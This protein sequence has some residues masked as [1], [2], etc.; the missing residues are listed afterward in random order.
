[1]G[2]KELSRPFTFLVNKSIS[3]QCFPS[4]LKKAEVSPLYKAKDALQRGNYRP[5]SIL[6]CISKLVERVYFDDLYAFFN[7]IFSV[8]I[9]AFRKKYGCQHVLTRLLID[10]K[11]ALDRREHAGISAL[12]LRQAFDCIPHPFLLSKCYHYG[13]SETACNIL[14]SYLSERTQRIK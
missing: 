7:N 13:V 14:W 1:M 11:A 9:S 10:I 4:Q 12:D 6:N 3:L 8:F 2:K 5:V